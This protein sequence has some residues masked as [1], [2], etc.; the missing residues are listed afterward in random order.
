MTDEI[1]IRSSELSAADLIQS[2]VAPDSGNGDLR[3]ELRQRGTRVRSI[4]QTVLVAIVGASGTALGALIAGVLNLAAQKGGRK[5][6]IV[7][8]TGRRLEITGR[9]TPEELEGY[10]QIAREIDAE[11]IK[12]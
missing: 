7:G 5:V 10:V 6:I 8:R 2:L 1:S 4:D 9:P 11:I 3:L 12:L